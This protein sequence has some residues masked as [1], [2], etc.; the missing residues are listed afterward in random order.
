L[1][2]FYC[3]KQIDSQLEHSYFSIE[4]NATVAM[5]YLDN[6]WSVD[7]VTGQQLF[8]GVIYSLSISDAPISSLLVQ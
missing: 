4:Y 6:P 2:P 1:H 3:S 7:V 8:S 5:T